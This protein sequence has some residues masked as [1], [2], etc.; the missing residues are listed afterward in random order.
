MRTLFLEPL[1]SGPGPQ[2]SFGGGRRWEQVMEPFLPSLARAFP[3]PRSGSCPVLYPALS[4]A[5]CTL[6]A[7]VSIKPFFQKAGRPQRL[8][9]SASEGMGCDPQRPCPTWATNPYHSGTKSSELRYWGL[10]KG[11]HLGKA[12]ILPLPVAYLIATGVLYRMSILHTALT[13]SACLF[14]SR[15]TLELRTLV[16]PAGK[17]FPWR[18]VS[19]AGH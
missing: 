18:A 6:L 5:G 19:T 17:L 13:V 3:F 9:A 4:A 2:A 12:C 7:L 16:R 14:P 15:R 11:S 10:I 8:T 1:G